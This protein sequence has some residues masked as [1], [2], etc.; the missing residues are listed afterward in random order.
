MYYISL[1]DE[2]NDYELVQAA[3]P[4]LAS[5]PSSAPHQIVS[6]WWSE[7][8]STSTA[9]FGVHVCHCRAMHLMQKRR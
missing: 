7:A 8:L 1:D 9:R 6:S 3:E 4:A 5:S 2:Y